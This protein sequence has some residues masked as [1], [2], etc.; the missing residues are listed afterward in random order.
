MIDDS[1]VSLDSS[2]NNSKVDAMGKKININFLTLN[3]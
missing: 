2:T 1:A 3:K